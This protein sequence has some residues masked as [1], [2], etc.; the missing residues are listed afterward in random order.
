MHHNSI[1]GIRNRTENWKTASTLAPL[2]AFNRQNE[3]ANML[4][5][6]ATS[7]QSSFGRDEVRIEL[8]WKGFRD[9]WKQQ[10]KSLDKQAMIHTAA[11]RYKRLFPSLRTKIEE[12]NEWAALNNQPKLNLYKDCNYVC[13]DSEE[14][15]LYDNLLNTEIDVV[16]SAPGFLL[17]G[18]AKYEQTFG[19]AS[20]H[21]LTHQLV[22]QYV[23]ASIV[24]DIVEENQTT[25]RAK[26]IPFIIGDNAK[27][28]AQ[29]KLMHHLNFLLLSNIITWNELERLVRSWTT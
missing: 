18:E 28:T 15:T 23:M 14:A 24:L 29:V 3:L 26:V 19:A 9:L 20:R 17:I 1:V 22:R 12:Y 13:L 5:S 11:D 10:S 8:F 25:N 21:M 4:I 6:N 27:A 7:S 2:I 16:M